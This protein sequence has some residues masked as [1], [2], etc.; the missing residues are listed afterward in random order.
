MTTKNESLRDEFK[1]L[2]R[3]LAVAS[4]ERDNKS[5]SLD[6]WIQDAEIGYW[7]AYTT[8][9][10]GNIAF[11]VY[12]SMLIGWQFRATDRSVD[13]LPESLRRAVRAGQRDPIP[14]PDSLPVIPAR[15]HGF[16]TDNGHKPAEFREWL[17]SNIEPE[18][19]EVMVLTFSGGLTRS[20]VAD[21]TDLPEGVVLYRLRRGCEAIEELG[22]DEAL[23]VLL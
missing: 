16:Q 10:P 9:E 4:F 7:K 5:R 15:L 22:F 19:V 20:E 14:A 11:E 17:E 21:A 23:M 1:D 13:H 6:E 3:R 8:F 18:D 2:P 12:A